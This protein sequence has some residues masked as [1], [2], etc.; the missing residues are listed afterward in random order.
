MRTN[1]ILDSKLVE[2]AFRYA[3]VSSKRAL[4]QLALQEFVENHRRHD[5]RELRGKIKLRSDYDH[6]ALRRDEE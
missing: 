4:I 5:I 2:E 6:K 1:I 3:H